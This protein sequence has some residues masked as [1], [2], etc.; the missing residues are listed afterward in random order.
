MKLSIPF[1]DSPKRFTIG[2]GNKGRGL[3]ADF[4]G[5]G[6]RSKI[7]DGHKTYQKYHIWILQLQNP[8]PHKSDWLRNKSFYTL[9]QLYELCYTIHSLFKFIGIR[10]INSEGQ[11]NKVEK[12]IVH[13]VH[14][15]FQ[16]Q[17]ILKVILKESINKSKIS[18]VTI[19]NILPP[20]DLI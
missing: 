12:Q 18:N 15:S 1:S 17:A 5:R 19:V 2:G 16:V 8:V 4:R 20:I 3:D 11:Y 10:T 6:V 7:G 9:G 13:T 14:Q